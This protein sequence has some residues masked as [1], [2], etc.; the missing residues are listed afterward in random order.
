MPAGRPPKPIALRVL[1]GN[2]G[3]RKIP[4][5]IPNV[6]GC[7]E[8]PAA[9]RHLN[10]CAKKKWKRLAPLLV[11]SG[12][13]SD[14]DLDILEHCCVSLSLA[15][16]AATKLKSDM[17][18]VDGKKSQYLS[19]YSEALSVFDRYGGKLGLSPSDRVKLRGVGIEKESDPLEEFLKN[20]EQ[21]FG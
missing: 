6:A 2:P 7:K 18:V 10:I 17:L 8:I 16:M 1:Q 3:K 11:Q 21:K 12:I 14:L 5:D 15:Q 13:L 19:V 4:T 9:P 20:G